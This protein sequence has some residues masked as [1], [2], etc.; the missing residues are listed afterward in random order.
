MWDVLSARRVR[1]VGLSPPVDLGQHRRYPVCFFGSFLFER[2]SAP[3]EGQKA[4]QG[5]LVAKRGERDLDLGARRRPHVQLACIG[6]QRD[7]RSSCAKGTEGRTDPA[8]RGILGRRSIQTYRRERSCAS[9]GARTCTVFGPAGREDGERFAAA[10]RAAEIG[11]EGALCAD[12]GD[13]WKRP[14]LLPRG[15]RYGLYPLDSLGGVAECALT[16][17][18]CV[19]AQ[20]AVKLR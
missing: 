20:S 10:A 15:Y 17:L 5:S 4:G 14:A 18:G 16:K 11:I 9:G 6:R 3:D 12:N 8:P 2:V 19:A 1:L 13:V 7:L